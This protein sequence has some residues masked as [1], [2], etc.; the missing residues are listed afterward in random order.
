MAKPEIVA[1][2]REV[3]EAHGW[4]AKGMLF[5]K[6]GSKEAEA[7]VFGFDRTLEYRCNDP[8]AKLPKEVENII[9]EISRG[10]PRH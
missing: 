5:E 2:V 1:R 9:A 6:Q 3:M 7:L 10:K 4:K 8:N